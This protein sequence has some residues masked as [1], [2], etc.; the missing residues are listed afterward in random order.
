LRTPKPGIGLLHQFLLRG[1]IGFGF[2][3]RDYI[4]LSLCNIN[5]FAV[6][7]KVYGIENQ[8][9]IAHIHVTE[10]HSHDNSSNL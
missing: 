7:I 4:D 3:L 9:K 5:A 8:D 10:R 6:S 2:A 1:V